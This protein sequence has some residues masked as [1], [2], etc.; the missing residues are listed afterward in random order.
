MPLFYEDTEYGRTYCGCWDARSMRYSEFLLAIMYGALLITAAC[1]IGSWMHIKYALGFGS[2]SWRPA[3]LN[4]A[5]LQ[6]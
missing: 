3:V 4:M 6:D 1:D 5:C 2:K